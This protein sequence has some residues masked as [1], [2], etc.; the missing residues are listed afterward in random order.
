MA[1]GRLL[2]W[3]EL[4][5]SQQGSVAAAADNHC[6]DFKFLVSVFNDCRN[7]APRVYFHIPFSA[8]LIKPTW[9]QLCLLSKPRSSLP[10]Q[11]EALPQAALSGGSLPTSPSPSLPASIAASAKSAAAAKAG[12]ETAFSWYLVD[13]GSRSGMSL[14]ERRCF[15][16]K[17]VQLLLTAAKTKRK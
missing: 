14:L 10:C 13:T 6:R 5:L 9:S 17:P 1:R 15:S 3:P 11:P 16:F 8:L 12:T 2:P 4:L 7:R